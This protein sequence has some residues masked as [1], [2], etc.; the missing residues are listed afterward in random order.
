MNFKKRIKALGIRQSQIALLLGKSRNT[1]ARQINETQG[2]KVGNDLKNM[3]IALEIL[4]Q[5]NLLDLYLQST[6]KSKE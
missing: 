4:Q 6:I 1:I 5:H 3:I 2:M